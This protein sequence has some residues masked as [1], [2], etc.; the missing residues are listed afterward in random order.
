MASTFSEL[1]RKAQLFFPDASSLEPSWLKKVLPLDSDLLSGVQKSRHA[2]RLLRK[3]VAKHYQL[4]VPERESLKPEQQWLLLDTSKQRDIAKQLGIYACANHI[5][6]AVTRTAVAQLR[7]YLGEEGYL[8]TVRA[9]TDVDALAVAGVQRTEFDQAVAQQYIG[10]YIVAHGIAL[11]EQTLDSEDP[12]F[13]L[14]MRFAFPPA[15]W[16]MRPQGLTVDSA[17]LSNLVNTLSEC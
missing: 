11:L 2:S 13:A 17:Q 12:F 7:D 8:T 4:V 9:A 14:R 10:R 15:C 3:A 16:N 6:T 5:R 1:G